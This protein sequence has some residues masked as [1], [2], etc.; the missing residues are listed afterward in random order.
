MNAV[1]KKGSIQRLELLLYTERVKS[2]VAIPTKLF[3]ARKRGRLKRGKCLN[4]LASS[5]YKGHL[6]LRL[7]N[8]VDNYSS[9]KE[10]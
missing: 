4:A 10:S 3:R 5:R 1:L 6:S 2:K 7:P 9:P 8:L